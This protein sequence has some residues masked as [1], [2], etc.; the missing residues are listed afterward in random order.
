MDI[1]AGEFRQIIDYL[2]VMRDECRDGSGLVVSVWQSAIDRAT[3]GLAVLETIADEQAVTV[4]AA[5]SFLDEL[6][7]DPDG[8]V[9]ALDAVVSRGDMVRCAFGDEEDGDEDE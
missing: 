1:Y 3:F 4:S 5:L 9:D 2:L 8:M 7:T 6:H